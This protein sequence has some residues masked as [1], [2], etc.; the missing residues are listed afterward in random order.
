MAV[1]GYLQGCV[2]KQ[3]GKDR[4]GILQLEPEWPPPFWVIGPRLDQL[5]SCAVCTAS[6]PWL[7]RRGRAGRGTLAGGGRQG[8]GSPLGRPGPRQQRLVIFLSICGVFLLDNVRVFLHTCSCFYFS[9]FE[10]S[11]CL[12]VSLAISLSLYMLCAL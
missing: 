1:V 10:V 4:L 2:G 8:C 11:L 7:K 12:D 6:S 9:V 5:P 3:A